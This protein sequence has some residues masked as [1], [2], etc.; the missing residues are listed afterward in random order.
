MLT[1]FICSSFSGLLS[2]LIALVATLFCRPSQQALTQ[3]IK[4]TN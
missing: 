4:Q 3:Q 1:Y 2:A